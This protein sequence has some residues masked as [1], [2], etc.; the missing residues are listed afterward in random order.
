MYVLYAR[1]QFFGVNIKLTRSY[2]PS[3]PEHM[4]QL[5]LYV[6]KYIIN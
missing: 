1:S 2:R 4:K 5:R 6:Y 3:L